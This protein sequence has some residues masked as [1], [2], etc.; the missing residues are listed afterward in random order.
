MRE[1]PGFP[2]LPGGKT[3][4][5]FSSIVIPIEANGSIFGE[6]KARSRCVLT[7]VERFARSSLSWKKIVTSFM[8]SRLA[9]IIAMMRL[10]RASLY[11][12]LNGICDPVNTTGL[13]ERAIEQKILLDGRK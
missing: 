11:G 5:S 4:C 7:F 2:N 13:P 1:G 9:K 8:V 3:K 12:S 10:R 6:S